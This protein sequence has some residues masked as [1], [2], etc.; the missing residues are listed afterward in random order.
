MISFEQTI[1]NMDEVDGEVE[2][3]AIISPEDEIIPV[4]PFAFSVDFS[5]EDTGD[6]T[7]ASEIYY[8]KPKFLMH[9]PLFLLISVGGV[10]YVPQ[11][12]T[13]VR[14][15]ALQ[16]RSCVTV[17]IIPDCTLEEIEFFNLAL[18]ERE[19]EDGRI[20]IGGGDADVR[21]SDTLRECTL[22]SFCQFSD[23]FP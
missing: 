1:Y 12:N 23:Q 3:C 6:P 11:Q 2:V 13:E 17:E 7:D 8:N 18:N 16:Q 21:I 9:L 5:T 4:V 15:E 14:F 20:K 22:A 10:D 19:G